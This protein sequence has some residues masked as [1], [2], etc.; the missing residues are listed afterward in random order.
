[1]ATTPTRSNLDYPSSDG[2]P[3]AETDDHRD[4]MV[5][6]IDTLRRFYAEDP[7][8]YVSG[9]LQMY[10]VPDDKRRHVSPDVFVVRGVAK[11]SRINYLVW[12][13]GKG[14][15]LVIE[16]TSKSTRKEDVWTKFKLYRDTLAV[17]EY[18]QFD[19]H[20]DYLKPPLKGYRLV[21]GRYLPIESVAGRLPSEVLGLHLERVG[22][23][24]RL[25]DP[26]SGAWLLTPQENN[27]VRIRAEAAR[28]Q[29]EAR[30]RQAEAQ[31]EELRRQLEALRNPLPGG[32]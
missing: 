27:A 26:A 8:T 15:D 13:E 30:Q 7:R 18:F 2:K 29:A 14:P 11:E 19:P 25:Y 24:L 12:E 17:R 4:I 16:V 23:N 5:D 22:R 28:D 32:S 9:N 10:Y 20:G 31:I 1:M 6:T 21:E 3:M